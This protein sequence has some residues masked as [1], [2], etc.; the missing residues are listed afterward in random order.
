METLKEHGDSQPMLVKAGPFLHFTAVTDPTHIQTVFRS[1]KHLSSKPGTLF[2]LRNLLSSPAHVIP[3]YDADDS[4][5]AAT[6]R[7]GSNTEQK[8]RIHYLQASAVQK[9]LS[10]QHLVALSEKFVSVLDRN[11]ASAVSSSEWVEHPDLYAFL[12][13]TVSRSAI[14]SLMGSAILDRHPDLLSQFWE[15]DYSVPLFLRCLPKWLIPSAYRA[16]SKLL[17]TV[18]SWHAHAHENSD[19]S[20]TGPQDPEWEPYFGSKLLRRRQEY[21]IETGWMDADA[22]AS[23]DMG[24][25][26]A[27]NGNLLPAVFWFVYEALKD[28]VLRDSLL[29]EV[30]PCM[31]GEGKE[32][33]D[34]M[35]L[36][37]QPL[38]Q[39]VYAETL[40]L[41]VAIA[42]T[43]VS[44]QNDFNLGGY[45]VPKGQPVVVFTRPAGLNEDA[46][47]KAGRGGCVKK[48][49]EEFWAERFLVD[50]RK[51]EEGQEKRK[52]FSMEGLAGC[53]LPYGGGQ[54]MCPGRHF[55]KNE[56]IGAFA[57]LFTRYELELLPGGQEP[58]PDLRWFPIGGLPPVGKVPFRIRKRST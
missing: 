56:M 27:S 20:R 12:Q 24:L 25:M 41:R 31:D 38:L 50:S 52:E 40:R 7:K 55:A 4:G 22:R 32:K 14:E 57:L 5:M 37:T 17:K 26:F 16:R 8:D 28:S 33:V 43:R 9:L 48:S 39:S 21:A 1:S 34:I 2:S 44:E 49:L 54:R 47:R 45:R 35:K 29:R 13:S 53:W 58:K 36:A 23:E 18:K 11:L 3:H 19:C 51:E 10:G 6:P 42:V 15:F 30:E 46:W